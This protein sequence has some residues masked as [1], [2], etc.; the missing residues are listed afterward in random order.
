MSMR[1]AYATGAATMGAMLFDSQLARAEALE[2]RLA[3]DGHAIVDK[4]AGAVAGVKGALIAS[5]VVTGIST[6]V[7][8]ASAARSRR[9]AR[10]G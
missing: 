7:L 3:T 1:G 5:A 4:A 10:R 2:K 6:A 8:V 9:A